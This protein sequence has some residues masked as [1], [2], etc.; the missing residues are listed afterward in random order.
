MHAENDDD[1][2]AIAAMARAL[3]ADPGNLEVLLSL[4][5]R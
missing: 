1:V 2:Q 5:V 4:G 3:G